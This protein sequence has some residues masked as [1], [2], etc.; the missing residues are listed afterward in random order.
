V[1]YLYFPPLTAAGVNAGI[2]SDQGFAQAIPV[3]LQRR[4]PKWVNRIIG[5]LLLVGVIATLYL[6]Y[7]GIAAVMR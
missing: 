5:V 2:K 6:V 4:Y 7:Y 3:L 1:S